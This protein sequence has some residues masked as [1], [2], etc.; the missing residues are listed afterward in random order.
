MNVWE[1]CFS[2]GLLKGDPPYNI[3][4]TCESC[5]HRHLLA[6]PR[7]RDEDIYIV[8]HDCELPNVAKL[9]LSAR[10]L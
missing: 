4:I 5:G 9:R 2:S 3:T 10:G 1:S 7:W 6:R 8:C